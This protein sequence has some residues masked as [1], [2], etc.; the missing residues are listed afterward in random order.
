M[1]FFLCFSTFFDFL[2]LAFAD[3]CMTRPAN[4][5]TKHKIIH[6]NQL[7]TNMSGGVTQKLAH[8]GKPQALT[9]LSKTEFVISKLDQIVNWV[10]HCH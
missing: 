7:A 9:G 10:R 4:T 2:V 6:I 8:F 5:F 3:V 1:R